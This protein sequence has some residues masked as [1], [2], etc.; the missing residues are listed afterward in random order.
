VSVYVV[1]GKLI[2]ERWIWKEFEGIGRG[3]THAYPEICLEG[4]IVTTEMSSSRDDIQAEIRDQHFAITILERYSCAE[5][6][7]LVQ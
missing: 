4:L 1:G 6:N 7:I 3:L 2:V 5:R